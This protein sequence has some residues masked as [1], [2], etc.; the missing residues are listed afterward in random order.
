MFSELACNSG[1]G[2]TACHG[3]CTRGGLSF[4]PENKPVIH[5]AICKSCT[6]FE[7]TDGCYH[8]ALKLCAQEYQVDELM[9]I[10]ERDANHWRSKGGVTFSGGEPLAQSDFLLTVLQRC[11]QNNFHTAIETTAYASQEIFLNVMKYID[12]AFIDVKHMNREKHKEKTGVYN[13]VIQSNIAALAKSNW[14][15]RLV[16]RVPVIKDFNDDD[17]TMQQLIDFMHTNKLVEVNL[18]PFHRLGAS[19]WTQLG[20]TY[21]YAETGD[22]S[23]LQLEEMQTMFLQ[24]DIACYIA[25]DTLF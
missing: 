11:K 15:G 1:K 12:F 19:K 24:Q 23:H 21:D 16:L 7:C 18:L 5:W 25:H 13:D 8:H 2:C 6:T 22:V 10:L 17:E 14:R 4:D 20:E 9:S 3:K